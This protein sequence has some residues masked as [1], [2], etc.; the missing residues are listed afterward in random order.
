V[1]VPGHLAGSR[2]V[3]DDLAVRAV[4]NRFIHRLGHFAQVCY[5]V[6]G[7]VH[8][9][10]VNVTWQLP[11]AAGGGYSHDGLAKHRMSLHTRQHK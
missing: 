10:R 11:S 1:P 2:E 5:Q 3:D 7:T 6:F 9:L 4:T 8:E